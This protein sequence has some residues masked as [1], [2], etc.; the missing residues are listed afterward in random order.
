MAKV[1]LNGQEEICHVKNTGRCRELLIPGREISVERSLNPGRK[2]KYDLI[3]V[4]TG[5]E[6]INIDSQVPN[7]VVEEWLSDS[8]LFSDRAVIQR[9][10][11]YRSSRFDFCVEDG[12][13]KAY[14]EVK[15]VTLKE[16]GTARFP[17]APT[18]RGVKHLEELI[19][20]V[21]EGYEA[22]LFFVIQMRGVHHLEPNWKTHPEFAETLQRAKNSG[23]KIL[24]YDCQVG[25]DFIRLH[26]PVPVVTEK[27][28]EYE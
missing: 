20:C 25:E 2:T 6:W 12:D 10:R 7:R 9:E 8:G 22:Y 26:K 14:M 18:S 19:R 23:V 21:E 13:R 24:A 4:F 3:A 5:E 11:K 17:D 16:D 28:E 27:E 15:G 1:R